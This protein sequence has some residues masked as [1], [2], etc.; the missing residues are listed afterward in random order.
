LSSIVIKSFLESSQGFSADRVVA[1]LV[2]NQEFIRL[3]TAY[4]ETRP[5]SDLNLCL[6]NLR[7]AGAL[8]GHRR[9]IRTSFRDE[10]EYRF[11]SEV[12]ARHIEKRSSITLDRIICDP[13]LAL[14]L[15]TIADEIAPG[16]SSLQYR[17]AALNLRKARALS[18]EILS[19]V[20]QPSSVSLGTVSSIAENDLPTGHGLYIFYSA[21][22]TLYVG[23]GQNL[24]KR[25][26]KHLDHS[27]NRNL[28]RWFWRH[29]FVDVHL[30]L[31]ILE[32]DVSSKIRKALEAEL[33]LS[34]RPIFNVQG[35]SLPRP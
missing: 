26:A 20:V 11:A 23:E 15:D 33:I 17:W 14:E 9:S 8:A 5:P 4:G 21:T 12:A 29:G 10:S 13:N 25:V 28:A 2:L 24:R 30:E 1:D 32:P 19:H 3:C 16:Y 6:L 27:D 7:K 22:G 35:V 34:R 18:P 31:Q